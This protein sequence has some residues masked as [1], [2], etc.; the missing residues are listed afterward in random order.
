MGGSS[1]PVHCVAVAG[2]KVV[3]AVMS[4][5]DTSGGGSGDV[6]TPSD[7]GKA[8]ASIRTTCA[9]VHATI[10][11]PL[12]LFSSLV[13]LPASPIPGDVNGGDGSSRDG[14]SS[15]LRDGG[16]RIT[17]TSSTSEG[18]RRSVS[19]RSR[20]RRSHCC[21]R[22]LVLPLAAE[23]VQ[24]TRNHI[25][26]RAAGAAPVAPV[27]H[28]RTTPV[29]LLTS[30]SPPQRGRRA[31]DVRASIRRGAERFRKE[32]GASGCVGSPAPQC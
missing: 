25:C 7:E 21:I 28:P 30:S 19:G 4:P 22:L 15:L 24:A 27:V 31:N 10:Q 11:P 3:D 20:A 18:G 5:H 32:I 12:T 26:R 13:L 1:P 16:I 14:N 2:G 9:P 8:T 17:A 23:T 6:D 29:V